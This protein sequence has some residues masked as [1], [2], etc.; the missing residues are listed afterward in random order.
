MRYLC[1]NSQI[2]FHTFQNTVSSTDLVD[3]ELHCQKKRLFPEKYSR[4]PILEWPAVPITYQVQS[5]SNCSIAVAS[6]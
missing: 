4:R 1:N 2:D 6:E 3:K 5:D